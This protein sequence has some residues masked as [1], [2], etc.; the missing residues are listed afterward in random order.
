MVSEFNPTYTS[1]NCEAVTI[2]NNF[3]NTNTLA[4]A[5][6]PIGTTTVVWTVKDACNNSSTCSFNVTVTDNQNATGYIIY[7]EKEAKFGEYNFIGGDVGVTA[8]NGKADFKKYDVLNPYRITAK[9][10]SVDNPSSVS[11]RTFSPATGGPNPT[12]YPYNGN[13]TGL[14]NFDITVNNFVLN[15]NW[16]DVKVKKGITATIKGNNFGKITIE[17]GANVTF[18]AGEINMK[19]LKV[20][21]GKKNDN[22]LTIQIHLLDLRDTPYT[23]VPTLAIWIPEHIG[24]DIIRQV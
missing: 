4:G 1:D 23:S 2:S 6:F 7:A 20:E 8:Y 3:N 13:T 12:F 9:N 10:I 19:E 14:S 22:I 24:R 18:T 17:E 15:G 5:Q 11:N 16:K 21:K